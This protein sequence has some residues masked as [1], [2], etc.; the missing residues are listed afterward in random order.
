M[1]RAGS[2]D[3]EFVWREGR[4]IVTLPDSM[5]KNI[6]DSMNDMNENMTGRPDGVGREGGC[7]PPL[8]GT[9]R[10]LG[11]EGRLSVRLVEA[12][13]REGRLEDVICE[14]AIEGVRVCG[15]CGRLM[16]EGWVYD[17]RETFCSDECLVAEHPDAEPSALRALASS[18]ASDTF[19]TRWE[20]P[21]P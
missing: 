8:R 21:P 18:D 14:Y 19:W 20:S 10:V 3:Y 15:C 2:N 9:E 16:D 11:R 6:P 13:R 17:G 7:L 5:N 4:N 1:R 12:L